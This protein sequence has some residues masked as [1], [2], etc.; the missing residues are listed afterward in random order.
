MKNMEKERGER[1]RKDAVVHRVC[2]RKE[3]K[4]R[5]GKKKRRKRKKKKTN[6]KGQKRR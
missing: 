3:K 2:E 1:D 5:K 4:R 6:R